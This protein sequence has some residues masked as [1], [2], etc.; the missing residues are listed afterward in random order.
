MIIDFSK[1]AGKTLYLENRLNQLSGQ[2]PAA[3][4]SQLAPQNS[5]TTECSLVLKIPTIR[6]Q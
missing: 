3:V 5:S 6:V 1:F 4:D 2:G